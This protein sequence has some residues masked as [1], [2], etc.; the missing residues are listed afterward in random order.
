VT[1][2]IGAVVALVVLACLLSSTTRAAETDQYYTWYVTMLVP[3][4]PSVKVGD[5][6]F[7]T[8]KLGHFLTNGPRYWR[9]Y[10]EARAHGLSVEEAQKKAVDLGVAQESGVLGGVITSTFSYGD[11]EANW[12][13]MQLIRSWCEGIDGR[14]PALT[15]DDVKGGKAWVLHERFAMSTWLNPCWDESFYPNA[16]EGLT[17]DGVKRALKEYCPL[18]TRPEV[19]AHRKRY[20]ELGCHSFS[21]AYLDELIAKG[22]APDPRPFTLE[23]AC[24][25]PPA[26]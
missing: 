25:D 2:R 1:S 4:D 19:A 6:M 5:I 22:E 21:V 26:R 14:P 18:R 7:G 3:V 8:D 12:Q 16:Y 24:G 20:R 15:L 13:G 9:V 10:S 11:L 23:A 17:A